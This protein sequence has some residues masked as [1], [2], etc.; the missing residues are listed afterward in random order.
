MY[1]IRVKRRFLG[2]KKYTCKSYRME[3][4]VKFLTSDGREIIAPVKPRLV[5]NTSDESIV[6]ISRIDERDWQI[7]KIQEVKQW[8]ENLAQKNS[9]EPQQT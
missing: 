2:W 4:D 8:Q 6:V 7:T 5:L 1:T 9:T 3:V